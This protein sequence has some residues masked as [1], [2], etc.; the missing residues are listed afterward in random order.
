GASANEGKSE[1]TFAD[2]FDMLAEELFEMNKMI[3]RRV[4]AVD[5]SPWFKKGK[6]LQGRGFSIQI[7]SGGNRQPQISVQTFGDVNRK[8]VERQL[9]S[10]LGI[11]NTAKPTTPRQQQQP[12]VRLPAPKTN[13]GTTLIRRSV[14]NF[15]EP[16]TSIKGIQNKLVIDLELPKAK[17]Q[18]IEIKELPSS[19]EVKAVVGDKAFFKILTKPENKRI[20]GKGFDKG[21]LHLEFS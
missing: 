10:Q 14:S 5:L 1:E 16:K 4:E 3:E 7:S 2:V 20:T 17:P 15:Q 13:E 6:G 21:V 9:Y 12:K 11:R 8:D 19:V 18:D